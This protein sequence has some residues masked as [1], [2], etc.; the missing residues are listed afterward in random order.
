MMKIQ[1][2]TTAHDIKV[3]TAIKPTQIEASTVKPKVLLIVPVSVLVVFEMAE[4][5]V[6]AISIVTVIVKTNNKGTKGV[7]NKVNIIVTTIN[8]KI[9]IR[10]PFKASIATLTVKRCALLMNEHSCHW[11]KRLSRNIICALL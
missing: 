2:R 7:R 6:K 4:M 8:E 10:I 9:T 3:A 11:R 5:S 1:H